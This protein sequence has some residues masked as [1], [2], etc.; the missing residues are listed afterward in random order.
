M[1]TYLQVIARL[2]PDVPL[3]QAQAH[4]DQVAAAL[5]RAHPVWNK[6]SQIGIRPLVDHL[7]GAQIK[8]WLLMLLAAVATCC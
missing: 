1:V 5:E 3:T 7:V 2:N 8:S 4:M 6:G